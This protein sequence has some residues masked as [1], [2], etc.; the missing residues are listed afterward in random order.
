MCDFKGGYNVNHYAFAALSAFVAENGANI[1]DQ[2]DFK[3]LLIE[4]VSERC[5]LL[6]SLVNI[7]AGVALKLLFNASVAGHII[8]PSFLILSVF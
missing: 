5:P 3:Y 8:K 2:V 1:F 7:R 6:C 4:L